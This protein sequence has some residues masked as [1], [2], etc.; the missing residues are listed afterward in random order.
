MTIDAS[1][2]YETRDGT[3]KSGVDYVFS[4][5][6]VSIPAGQTS[7]DIAIDILKTGMNKVFSLVLSNPIGGEFPSGMNIMIATH[8]IKSE[9]QCGTA[10]GKRYNYSDVSY[11]SYSQCAEGVSSNT[12]FPIEGQMI[13]WICTGSD[14]GSDSTACFTSRDVYPV[15]PV[16]TSITGECGTANGKLYNYTDTGYGSDSQCAKGTVSDT[17]FPRQG[18]SALWSCKGANGGGDSQTCSSQRIA[19][20]WKLSEETE[21]HILES[22][23]DYLSEDYLEE[24][25]SSY[26]IVSNANLLKRINPNSFF[27]IPD[28]NGNINT[29]KI[30]SS[31]ISDEVLMIDAISDNQQPFEV[32]FIEGRFLGSFYSKTGDKFSIRGFEKDG[33]IYGIISIPFLSEIQWTDG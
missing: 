32:S 5:G 3:A 10:N 6:R 4:S 1:V 15:P 12:A 23:T 11:G 27:S 28:V 7:I 13:T 17:S 21:D 29:F 26:L 8:K 19:E 33:K 9:G 31:T 16:S 25:K 20:L 18:F 22:D 24:S 14:G 30:T 2:A